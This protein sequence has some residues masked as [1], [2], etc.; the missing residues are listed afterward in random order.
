MKNIELKIARIRSG[1]RL[2]D[3]AIKTGISVSEISLFEN[4][5]KNPRSDQAIKLNEILGQ[6]IYGVDQDT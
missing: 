5:L 4:G 1:L 3:V 2:I 6:K